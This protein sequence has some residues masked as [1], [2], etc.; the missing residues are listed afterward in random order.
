MTAILTDIWRFPI[1]SHGWEA[2]LDAALTI[3]QGLPFDRH[4]AVAH[5]ASSADGSEW[6]PCSQFS[7]GAKAPGLSAIS[8][9]LNEATRQV[10]LSHP[11]LEDL[12]FFP[13]SEGD[14][15]ITW[16][17][18]FLPEGRAQSDRVIRGEQRGFTDADFPSITLCNW[19]S[20][21]AVEEKHGAPL[22]VHRWRGNLWIEGLAPWAEFDWIDRDI[23]I[24]SA[25][26]RVIEPTRRCLATHNDPET[27]QRNANILAVLDRFG[28]Q[29][30]SV[31]TKV[32]EPGTIRVNDT[33]ELL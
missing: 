29:D 9:E 2:I 28:H 19:A 27:G 22:S 24:G 18:Q 6:V 10:T 11:D 16:A 21:R 23:R 14:K 32:V 4:W 5:D 13:D 30:F 15:L 33:V 12:T 26:L 31:Q 3:G 7:R 17:G 1:K 8:C 20:H 25:V